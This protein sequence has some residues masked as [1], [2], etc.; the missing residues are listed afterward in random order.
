[1]NFVIRTI[2]IFAPE[3]FVTYIP[4]IKKSVFSL[5][6]M[7]GGKKIIFVVLSGILLAGACHH[8]AQVTGVNVE[9]V[10][11][12]GKSDVHD[13]ATENII[14]PYKKSLDQEMNAVICYSDTAMNKERGGLE[15]LLGN[16]TADV[17][18]GKTNER[19]TLDDPSKYYDAQ[20]CLLNTGGLRNSLPK[21]NI[22]KGNIFELMPF[23][24]EIVVVTISGKNMWELLRYI[25]A[26]GGQPV[27][28]IKMGLRNDKTP[29]KVLIDGIPLDTTKTYKV[30]TSDYLANGGDK[31]TFL[32]NPV[33]L[34]TTGYKIRDALLDYCYD[35][36]R[37]GKH[38]HPQLDGRI[39][40]E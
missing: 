32:M 24:N 11:M 5:V 12:N 33:K 7:R 26:T 38:L 31:M 16:F 40:Y 9:Y 30:A 21:G 22:T 37:M 17:V 36:Q 27:S 18:L 29:G 8:P 3:L 10:E 14:G 2:I 35:Q 20:I 4:E 28:G 19:Y 15:S 13:T 25:A 23:D 39:Y 34:E 6:K 1:M